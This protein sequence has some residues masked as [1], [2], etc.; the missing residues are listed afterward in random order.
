M[1]APRSCRGCGGG[2]D[3]APL[4]AGKQSRRPAHTRA[5]GDNGDGALFPPPPAMSPC[6]CPPPPPPANPTGWGGDVSAAPPHPNTRGKRGTPTHTC[7]MAGGTTGIFGGGGGHRRGLGG[8]T[9]RG[10]ARPRCPRPRRGG[11]HRRRPPTSPGCG[12][13]SPRASPS[14]TASPG[15]GG[16]LRVILQ[17]PPGEPHKAPPTW[18][19]G[20]S[21]PLPHAKL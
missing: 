14:P 15:V 6:V 7:G 21:A 1:P 5:A 12:T 20:G 11:G 13:G 10:R 3:C 17:I 2:S 16:G 19:G 18:G 8:G 4:P 9:H